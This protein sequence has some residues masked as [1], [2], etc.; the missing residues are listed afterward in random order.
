M[1]GALSV[2]TMAT[3]ELVSMPPTSQKPL[4]D[5]GV[6]DFANVAGG[7]VGHGESYLSLIHISE[8]TRP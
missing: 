2:D 5:A 4:G 7:D 3:N 6:N 8:P 1:A